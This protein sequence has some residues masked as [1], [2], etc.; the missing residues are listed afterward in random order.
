MATT[1]DRFTPRAALG[2]LVLGTLAA[3]PPVAGKQAAPPGGAAEGSEDLRRRAAGLDQKAQQQFR[4]GRHDEALRSLNEALA[5]LRQLYPR[6]KYPRGHREL[7]F[8]LGR[9]AELH[10]AQGDFPSAQACFEETLAAFE[11]LYP[12]DEFPRG[13]EELIT[14]LYY[15]AEVRG[16]REDFRGAVPY[17]RRALEMC[18]AFYG[19]ENHLAVANCLN[20]LAKLHLRAGNRREAREYAERSLAVR[21]ALFPRK[22]FSDGHPELALGLLNLGYVLQEQGAYGQALPHYERALAVAEALRPPKRYPQGDF[23]VALCLQSLGG[24]HRDRGDFA[25]AWSCGERGLAMTE[26]LCRDSRSPADRE[27][28]AR[29]LSDVALTYR[30]AGELEKA[31][32]YLERAL[33][34]EED[35]HP[36]DRSPHG[37]P[38][39]LRSLNNLAGLHKDLED[40]GKAR[41]GYERALAMAEALYPPKAFPRGH[42]NLAL[43]LTN[44]AS[45]LQ[46]QG[47][48]GRA[49]AYSRRALEVHRSLYP[50]TEYPNGHPLLAQDFNNVGLMLQKKGD[51]AGARDHFE[52]A[53]AAYEALYPRR[54]Y[55]RGHPLLAGSLLNLTALFAEQED[56]DRGLVCAEQALAACRALYPRDEFPRGSASLS[57]ALGNRA[58]YLAKKGEYGRALADQE[59]ALAVDRALYPR[60]HAHL[61]GTLNN[62]VALH[63]ARGEVARALAYAREAVTMYQGLAEVFVGAAAEAEALNFLAR[64]PATRDGFLSLPHGRLGT[65]AADV[66]A[67]A[68]RGKALVGRL[69][70]RR[71]RAALAA[72]DPETRDLDDRL[73]AAGRRLSGLLLAPADPAADRV[74]ALSALVAEK[75]RLERELARKVGG[76]TGPGAGPEEL[77]R[78]LPAGTAFIDFLRYQRFSQ[79]PARPGRS[80]E[81]RTTSYLAFVLCPGGP[82][83]VVDLGPA[84]PVDDAVEA[85]RRDLLA[86]REGRSGGVLCR[87]VWL[88]VA[89]LLPAGTSAVYLCPDGALARIPWAALPGGKPGTVL[90]EDHAL[91]VVPHGPFLLDRLRPRDARPAG[92]G[93]LLAVG[94]VRYGTPPAG[95]GGR[96]GVWDDLPATAGEARRV[97]DLAA[98]RK[99]VVLTGPDAGTDRLLAELPRARWAHLATHGF[100]ADKEVRSA[101]QLD[102]RQFRL[103]ATERVTPGARSPLVLSGLVLAGANLPHK[104]GGDGSLV[105]AEAIVG[106]PLE[107]LDLA[108]LSACETGLGEVA[109]GE[110]VFGLQRAFH[111]A[112]TRDILASLWRVDDEGTAALMALFYHHLWEKNLPPIEALRQAQL[113]VY[114]HPER[115]KELAG[116]RGLKLDKVVKLPAAPAPGEAA[117]AKA[118]AKLW[119]G[120][121]LSGPGRDYPPAGL[122]KS[123]GR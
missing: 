4:E 45:L 18:Q 64:L 72:R 29:A 51:L 80:G 16:A 118:P 49:L 58:Y 23:L 81:S 117:R 107:G 68:W 94:G 48:F 83:R 10:K 11:T 1:W 66:Y 32:P 113:T 110:G 37:H 104:P 65:P 21:E 60:G 112:G 13:R 70:E 36:K 41:A 27:A 123:A 22:D 5:V 62:L 111:L 24:L 103:D 91:A 109:G 30:A 63:Q 55:P 98:P 39:L 89:G 121:V 3:D 40:Y 44:L 2:L 87:L 82:V 79:D 88:P 12:K 69:L 56:F 85:W 71:H 8:G 52:R 7:A 9:R 61:A 38:E 17:A 73:R 100:F 90:L 78:R 15:L 115:V 33:A 26:A 54:D 67:P 119:A 97:A 105:A 47:E 25:K 57:I 102:E 43:A 74:A 46:Q 86:G 120:F 99:A 114:R 35:L 53:V 20:L 101:F 50:S 19:K 96:A 92:D 116:E 122:E 108:V 42:E 77:A 95:G 14:C 84:A 93:T 59:E 31:L 76:A 6:D 34:A 106:L 28:V 75:E